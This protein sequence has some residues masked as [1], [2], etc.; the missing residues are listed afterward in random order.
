M[1]VMHDNDSE[2]N[3]QVMDRNVWGCTLAMVYEVFVHI[4]KDDSL[5]GSTS[6]TGLYCEA[7]GVTVVSACVR[8][9]IQYLLPY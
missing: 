2:T 1:I 5:I 7:R 9:E 8:L 3:I 6:C 4:G